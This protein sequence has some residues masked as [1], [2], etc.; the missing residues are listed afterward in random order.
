M[1]YFRY[2]QTEETH[3]T[4][5]TESLKMYVK[6]IDL[7]PIKLRETCDCPRFIFPDFESKT[8]KF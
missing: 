4:F 1:L 8:Q 6:P 5:P 3:L 2:T 7:L